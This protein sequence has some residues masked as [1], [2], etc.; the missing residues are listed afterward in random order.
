VDPV[1]ELPGFFTQ[2]AV[3]S[4]V[5]GD[6][7]PDAWKLLTRAN[8]LGRIGDTSRSKEVLERAALV[9]DRLIN[10]HLALAAM[11]QSRSDWDEAVAR[12]RRVL[13]HA[14]DHV[15]AMNDLAYVL[16]ENKQSP[17]EALPLAT[18]AYGL[19]KGQP[20][21]G[22]TLAWTQHLLGRDAEAAP[23][24]R[25]A[26]RQVP[27]HP[28]IQFHAAVILAAVGDTAAAKTA[29]DAAIKLNQALAER[30]DVRA[31]RARLEGA[32]SKPAPPAAK[33]VPPTSKPVP[34]GK[35]APQ[36]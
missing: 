2:H 24:I 15:T 29:L 18:R 19:S 25:Q 34:G 9:D 28:D 36:K 7:K 14:P 26:A 23:L 30:A 4:P 11:A 27:R 3:Q 6:I 8:H 16:A 35:P 17:E 5:R 10:A 22:D 1:S 21:I 32:A 13:A 33:P 31:L 20:V 12:Y